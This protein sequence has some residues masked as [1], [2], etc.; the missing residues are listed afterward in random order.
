MKF[1]TECYKTVSEEALVCSVP[2]CD[3]TLRCEPLLECVLDGRYAPEAV[4]AAGGMGVLLRARHLHL[5]ALFAIK[6]LDFQQIG[7]EAGSRLAQRF[8]SEATLVARLRHPNIVEVSDFG[9]SPDGRTYIVMEFLEGRD[10][11]EEIAEGGQLSPRRILEV[12]RPVCEALAWTHRHNVVHRDIK[13]ANIMLARLGGEEC[14]KLLDFGVAKMME[15]VSSEQ[16]PI[17][18]VVGTPEYM[19]PEQIQPWAAPMGPM[20]DIY[21]LGI[22][23]FEMVAGETPFRH[24][25]LA[26]IIQSKMRC[27]FVPLAERRPGSGWESVDQVLRRA[28]SVSPDDR[29]QS[30]LLFLEELEAALEEVTGEAISKSGSRLAVPPIPVRTKTEEGL[31]ATLPVV[32]DLLTGEGEGERCSYCLSPRPGDAQFCPFCG[33][34]YPKQGTDPFVGALV[35]GTYRLEERLRPDQEPMAYRATNVRLDQLVEVKLTVTSCG[36]SSSLAGRVREEARLGVQLNHRGL[37]ATL[38][39]GYDASMGTCFVVTEWLE[40]SD[41]TREVSDNGVPARVDVRRWVLSILDTIGFLHSQEIAYKAL[42]PGNLVLI[43]RGELLEPVL[44]D[45]HAA[46]GGADFS[47]MLTIGRLGAP[48]FMAPEQIWSPDRLDMRSDIYGV[49][50]LTYF[51]LTGHAPYSGLGARDALARMRAGRLLSP[52][53]LAPARVSEQW[54]A[55]VLRAMSHRPEDRFESSDEMAAEVR[56]A[57]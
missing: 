4:H 21:A 23:V 52:R 17:T 9:T 37:A 56:D 20:T 57:L 25:S 7:E 42:Q 16:A 27:R 29:Q 34:K 24:R 49:G 26:H 38:D 28:L 30:A 44:L 35:D 41:L 14:V 13:P 10:L 8:R 46:R 39:G 11:D 32:H 55:L 1:C 47:R 48:H 33:S 6:V 53:K 50:A 43:Q 19:A 15:P 51:C 2:G 22:T 54:E 3:G 40:G 12:M 36:G 31:S 5:E 45:L 18:M